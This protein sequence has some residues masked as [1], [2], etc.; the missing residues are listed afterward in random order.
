MERRRESAPGISVINSAKRKRSL[1]RSYR[2]REISKIM[3]EN[4]ALLKRLQ[5]KKSN[6]NV[7]KWDKDH[8]MRTKIL[9]NICQYPYQFAGRPL[10]Y[11]KD[12]NENFETLSPGYISQYGDNKR[13]RCILKYINS[14]FKTITFKELVMYRC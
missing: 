9:T 13:S 14:I 4:K 1:N 8:Q 11:I 7:N 5:T 6:Y 3:S 12:K 10:K 2:K